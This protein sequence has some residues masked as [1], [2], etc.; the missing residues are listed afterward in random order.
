MEPD[1][2]L[3]GPTKSDKDVNAHQASDEDDLSTVI[4]YIIE[5]KDFENYQSVKKGGA[6]SLGFTSDTKLK[7]YLMFFSCD[8]GTR[9]RKGR[10]GSMNGPKHFVKYL[11][12]SEE[13]LK[14]DKDKMVIYYIG[15]L[16]EKYLTKPRIQKLITNVLNMNNQV[17]FG[18]GGSDDFTYY[19][20]KYLFERI[21]AQKQD[22]EDS[23]DEVKKID[24]NIAIVHFD[25]KIDMFGKM[26]SI[27]S[28]N[29]FNSIYH[30]LSTS[31]IKW[32]VVFIGIQGLLCPSQIIDEIDIT[33][34]KIKTEYIWMRKNI[35]AIDT[36]DQKFKTSAGY[37]MQIL[38]DLQNEGFTNIEASFDLSVMKSDEA[39]GRSDIVTADGFTKDE[40][41][42]ASYTTHYKY[43]NIFISQTV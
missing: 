11:Q 38:T 41:W 24:E 35:R 31:D 22:P 34:S 9:D 28:I 14:F 43:W 33:Y 18:I 15:N 12:N 36:S 29:Y 2:F 4:D 10:V 27:T 39:P 26:N 42:E 1:E 13:K 6:F 7:V 21:M 32:K 3:E 19:Y 30:T 37:A 17:F 16:I 23:D 40:I 25:S 20:F 8:I 5:I